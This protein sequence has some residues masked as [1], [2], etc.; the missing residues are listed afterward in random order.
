MA[1]SLKEENKQET[2]TQLRDPGGHLFL[3]LRMEQTLQIVLYKVPES[4]SKLTGS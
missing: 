4:Q 1:V 2:H 3:S